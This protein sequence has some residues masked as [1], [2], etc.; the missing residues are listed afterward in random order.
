[1]S[2]VVRLANLYRGPLMRKGH[3]REIA[4]PANPAHG[5]HWV[6]KTDQGWESTPLIAGGPQHFETAQQ[7]ID[8][9]EIR[10]FEVEADPPWFEYTFATRLPQRRAAIKRG[11][12]CSPF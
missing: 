6:R 12:S 9:A 2:N 8:Y 11:A 3:G 1:M 5:W 7:A 10:G 4:K